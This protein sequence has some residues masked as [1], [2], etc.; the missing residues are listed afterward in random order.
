MQKNNNSAY[1]LLSLSTKAF[2]KRVVRIGPNVTEGVPPCKK[3]DLDVPVDEIYEEIQNVKKYLRVNE[4]NSNTIGWKAFC[5]HGQS[6]H[7]TQH[8]SAY[9]DFLG[10]K[11]T[12]EALEH[13]PVTI[14]WL[15]S[16][17]YKS[18]TRVRVMCLLPKGIINV[19][20]D[21]TVSKLDPVN[22]AINNP[23][24][25]KFYLENHGEL[26]FSPGVAYQLNLVN[27]HAVVNDSDVHRYHIIIHGSK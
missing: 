1:D 22:V 12:P 23:T 27:H 8:D 26:E 6:L 17:G 16:L 2:I 18:F 21:Q 7:R 25:C 3:L 10:H 5:I 14:K 4:P 20:K 11:W 19:H 13:M 15:K 24:G 9:S